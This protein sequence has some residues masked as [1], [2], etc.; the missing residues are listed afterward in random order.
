MLDNLIF[1]YFYRQ[2]LDKRVN[3]VKELQSQALQT[4]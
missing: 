4:A 3:E 1:L 2:K